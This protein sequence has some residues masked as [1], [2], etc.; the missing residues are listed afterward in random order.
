MGY[1]AGMNA[2]QCRPEDDIDRLVA[3]PR[4]VS[5]TAAAR[6]QLEWP[7]P[8]AH[9]AFTRLVP[10]WEPDPAARWVAV[11]PRVRRAGGRGR[12]ASILDQPHARQS[13]PVT[14]HSTRTRVPASTGG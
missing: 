1:T 12:D 5:G 8:P 7:R 11:A 14:R 4:G 3:A 9:D 2:P 6:G 10:R 13:G